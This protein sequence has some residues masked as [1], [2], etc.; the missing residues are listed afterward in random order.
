MDPSLGALENPFCLCLDKTLGSHPPGPLCR[1]G[2]V[3]TAAG[4]LRTQ[5]LGVPRRVLFSGAR[6][7]TCAGVLPP[8]GSPPKAERHLSP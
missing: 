5:W 2:A 4:S 6:G 8:S 7:A 1:S 3:W